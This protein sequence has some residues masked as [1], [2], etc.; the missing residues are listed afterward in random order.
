TV[1][2]DPTTLAPGATVTCEADA[3]YVITQADVDAGTVEN[4]A[5]ATGTPPTGPPATSK[6]DETITELDDEPALTLDKR[7]AKVTDVDGDGLTDAGDT[8]EYVFELVNSGNV[9]LTDLNVDDPM[10][11]AAGIT[12]SCPVTSLAPSEKVT[13]VADEEYIITAADAL[14][15]SVRNTATA[16]YTPPGGTP[17]VTPP[18]SV[19]TPTE[20]PGDVSSGETPPDGGVLP[21]TGGPSLVLT[22]GAVVAVLAGLV[23]VGRG[24]RR[25]ELA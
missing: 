7:A 6:P 2:C 4:V 12:I 3:P 19:Q 11:V 20:V 17:V 5:T 15:G 21:N 10:L 16:A 14:A 22:V 25:H 23:L 13:C 18:D 1:T 8:I 24:R 9:T